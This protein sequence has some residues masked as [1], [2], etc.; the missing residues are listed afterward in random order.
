MSLGKAKI[1]LVLFWI[2]IGFL[3]FKT[4][5]MLIETNKTI[6]ATK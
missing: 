4:V 5:K 6:E 2:A 3:M 1:L